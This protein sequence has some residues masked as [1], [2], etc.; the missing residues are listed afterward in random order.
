MT[1]KGS[2]SRLRHR[3]FCGERKSRRGG[4]R[5]PGTW[6]SFSNISNKRVRNRQKFKH[7][8]SCISRCTTNGFSSYSEG[9]HSSRQG[10][11]PR[12][13]FGVATLRTEGNEE[14]Q[15]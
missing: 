8:K 15:D 9:F 2:R 5:T 4:P 6:F 12:K 13:S 7:A 1:S 14:K 3:A 11:K 10:S